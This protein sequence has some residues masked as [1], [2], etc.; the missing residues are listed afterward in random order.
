MIDIS[1]I[2][3]FRDIYDESGIIR[4]YSNYVKKMTIAIAIAFIITAL[5]SLFIYGIYNHFTPYKLILVTFSLSLISTNLTAFLF[6][7]YPL[8]IRNQ[9]Q[10]NIENDLIY[11]LSY[12]KII[13]ASGGT[14]DYLMERVAD[15]EDNQKIRQLATK[16]VINTKLLGFDVSQAIDNVS[17]RTPSKTL[18]K[19]LENISHNIKTSGDLLTLFNY[20]INKMLVKKREDLKKLILSLTYFG[21]IYVALFVVG[22]I[23]FILIIIIMSNFIAGGT[24]SITQLNLVVFVGLPILASMFLIILDTTFEGNI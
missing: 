21:E 6:L 19:L 20:E 7:F 4:P 24:A 2:Q 5:F 23:L 17:R 11:S 8:Y 1:A 16:Y 13:A 18:K 3:E 9:L 12:I 10:S 15:V 22:P 14:L